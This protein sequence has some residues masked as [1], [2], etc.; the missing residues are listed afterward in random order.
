MGKAKRKQAT[1]PKP[2]A[3][4]KPKKIEFRLPDVE[5]DRQSLIDS[6]FNEYLPDCANNEVLKHGLTDLS[7]AIQKLENKDAKKKGSR[8]GK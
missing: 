4:P 8:R 3:K 5:K 7:R 2:Q 1:K 6:F